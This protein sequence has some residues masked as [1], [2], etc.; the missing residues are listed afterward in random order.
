VGA[1]T[2]VTR[3][4]RLDDNVVRAGLNYRFNWPSPAAA[5]Y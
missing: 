3:N 5:W 4:V 2:I 1:G